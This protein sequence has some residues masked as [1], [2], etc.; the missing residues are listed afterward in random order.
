MAT[1]KVQRRLRDISDSHLDD[2]CIEEDCVEAAR[3]TYRVT[4]AA[5]LDGQIT[6]GEARE[7]IAAQER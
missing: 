3:H 4:R 6:V 5:L 2:T 7:I 1:N